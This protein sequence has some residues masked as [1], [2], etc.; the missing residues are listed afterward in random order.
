[1]SVICWSSHPVWDLL[2]AFN[3]PPEIIIKIFSF[4]TILMS[5]TSL[6]MSEF[7]K[8]INENN[9]CCIN[10][11]YLRHNNLHETFI[12]QLFY[13]DSNIP[14]ERYF[15]LTEMFLIHNL[16]FK[17][18]NKSVLYKNFI[19]FIEYYKKISEDPIDNYI[20]LSKYKDIDYKKDLMETMLFTLCSNEYYFNLVK[21]FN[22][23]NID[24]KIENYMYD[25]LIY[26]PS[27]G[28]I[29]FWKYMI[30]AF[31]SKKKVTK[32]KCVT[33]RILIQWC[34]ILGIKHF[35]S[36]NKKKLIT[37]IFKNEPSDFDL[38]YF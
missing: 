31:V 20:K 29:Y 11:N 34:N 22:S 26:N 36:W 24:K 23:E 30:S 13:V 3:L 32:N 6:A 16:R 37:S 7:S 14:Y 17:P 8:I 4:K 33:H 15:N 28:Q 18:K 10:C 9:R 27:L 35:K 38:S 21:I 1:M 19:E 12:T 2:E 25:S 5:P